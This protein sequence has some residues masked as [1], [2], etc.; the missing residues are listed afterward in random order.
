MQIDRSAVDGSPGWRRHLPNLLTLLRL[1]FAAAFFLALNNYWV[2]RT[3]L[4]PANLAVALFILAAVT[5]ALDGYYAR[6]WQVVS[7]FGRIMDPICDKVLVMGAFIYLAGP[8]FVDERLLF[9]E[10]AA[11]GRT[12]GLHA[13]M[14]IL[15]LFRELLITGIRSVAESAGITFPSNWWGKAKMILQTIAIPAILV[16]AVNIDLRAHGWVVWVRD[17]LV[18]LTL[19]VTVA[20]G[21]P[22]ITHFRQ[23]MRAGGAGGQ[24]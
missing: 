6:K 16:I 7:V 2:N 5:D 18:W 22:Y 19:L 12:S 17:G 8:R 14:V 15:I 4:W 10:G 21:I 11:L 13:W 23:T 9:E 24:G 20:S 3:P 1:V